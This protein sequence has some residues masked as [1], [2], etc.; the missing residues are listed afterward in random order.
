MNV[1]HR[2]RKVYNFFDF[3]ALTDTPWHEYNRQWKDRFTRWD[4]TACECLNPKG[5]RAEGFSVRFS[6]M[7]KRL[8]VLLLLVAACLMVST[9][10]LAEEPLEI[11]MLL[12]TTT[13]TEPAE[14]DVSIKISN[15]SD[16]ELPGPMNL[17]YPDGTVVEEFG[18]PTLA[19]GTSTSWSGKWNVTQ[20]ELESGMVAFRLSYSVTG[21]EGEAV[22]KLKALAKR[23]TYDGGVAALEVSRTIM[24][25][26]A[27]EGQKVSVTYTLINTG[28][29]PVSDVEI[30]ENKN[31]SSSK[32]K[33]DSIAVGEKASYTFTAT[34]QKKDLTSK[35]AIAYTAG[36]KTYTETTENATIKYGVVYLTGALA[37]DKKGGAPGDTVKL[38]LT[39]KNTGKTDY[40][41]INVS[42]AVLGEVFS[43]QSVAAGRTVTLEKEITISETT[44]YQFV[45][46]G[47]DTA[48][49]EVETA[50]DR[51]SITAVDPSQ[52]ANLQ[53]ELTVDRETIYT[54]PGIVKFKADVTNLSSADMKNVSVQAGGM[55]L[56]TFSSLLAGE[57]RSFVRDVQV[58]M[59]GQFQFTATVRDQLGETQTF[60]SNI[61]RI[62]YA[63][64]T[65]APTEVPIIVPSEPNYEPLPEE[66]EIPAAY[67][68]LSQVLRVLT[69]LF[70]VLAA[71]AAVLALAAVARRVIFVAGRSRDRL[72]QSSVRDYEQPNVEQGEEEVPEPASLT[73]GGDDG[74]EVTRIVTSEIEGDDVDDQR[75]AEE[76]QEQSGSILRRRPRRTQA[77]EEDQAAVKDMDD[78]AD[79]VA[80]VP[81]KA[82][83]NE[84]SS[85]DKE[86]K[87]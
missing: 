55:T 6:D 7:K 20:E 11:K 23:I 52:V 19:G 49:N 3:M 50:T 67:D 79:D 78:T 62:Q 14:V 53:V 59:A 41:G 56:Y 26:T 38:T 22:K 24:P 30:T 83:E 47:A 54:L 1:T 33:I 51:V 17:Y 71:L 63:L 43:G 65:V 86:D 40:T 69:T 57:T 8:M 42:D 29:L 9:A 85:E 13:F 39:L 77:V 72:D 48:G 80:D 2:L 32:G 84:E 35:A 60:S 45:I 25:T 75:S 61:V 28:T 74:I 37:A 21:E 34:M 58:E 70:G 31:I 73:T 5:G 46:R 4:K 12:S 76:T 27:G 18:S 68:V 36:G 16:T 15:T 66:V 87:E 64:P 81:E 44:D 10:A 82:D